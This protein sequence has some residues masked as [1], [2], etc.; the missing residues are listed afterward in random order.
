MQFA[1]FWLFHPL[2]LPPMPMRRIP[3]EQHFEL[4]E[5]RSPLRPAELDFL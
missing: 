1:N 5:K 3:N 2:A 4:E